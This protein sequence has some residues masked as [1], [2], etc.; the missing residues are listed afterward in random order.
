MR[1]EDVNLRSN[2]HLKRLWSC[3]YNPG[4]QTTDTIDFPLVG[5]VAS[6]NASCQTHIRIL[7]RLLIAGLRR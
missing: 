1:L 2:S 5:V 3:I 7:R 4:L 6:S